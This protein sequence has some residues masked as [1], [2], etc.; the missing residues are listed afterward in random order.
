MYT[1]LTLT[2]QRSVCLCFSS[3]WT[4]G[5]CHHIW[6][7]YFLQKKNFLVGFKFSKVVLSPWSCHLPFCVTVGFQSP[8]LACLHEQTFRNDFSVL[9]YK[10]IERSS[11]SVHHSGPQTSHLEKEEGCFPF[12][13][14]L[15]PLSSMVSLTHSEDPTYGHFFGEL[16]ASCICV[17]SVC[18]FKICTLFLWFFECVLD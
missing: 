10:G 18:D 7:Q 2:S 15:G 16:I 4:K 9:I 17:P 1:R 3:A 5:V 11:K 14:Y 13:L 12:R 6:L 8:L